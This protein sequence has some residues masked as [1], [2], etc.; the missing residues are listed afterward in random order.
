MKKLALISLIASCSLFANG[1]KIPEN[2]TNAV[3][4]SAANVAHSDGADAAYYNP[5]NM[6]FMEDGNEIDVNLMYI[7]L[8]AT[9]FKGSGTMDGVDINANDEKFI[10]PS[11][12]Y[13]SPKFGNARFGLSIV[14]PGGLTK[15]W[16]DSPAVD[17]AEEFTLKIIE[18][19]PTI[20]YAIN[21]EIAV[22]FGI[23]A[24]HSS[25]V[26]KST[27]AVSRDLTGESIDMGYNVAVSYKPNK[28]FDLA[29]TYR[30]K[31]DL[32]VEGDASLYDPVSLVY[33][34][35]A[36]VTVPLPACLNVAIAHNIGNTTVELVYERNFWSAYKKLD[37]DYAGNIGT[38]EPYFDAP[39]TKDWKDSNAFRLGVTHKMDELT[40]MA[41]AVYSESP[42][43]DERLSFELPDANSVS[44]SLGARYQY[45]K[46]I[47]VGLSAL[48]SM[49]EKRDVTN[50]DLSGEFS[51]SNI[52]L[53]SAGVGYK[54]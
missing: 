39:I 53:V 13:V 21:N 25:G 28:K 52:L 4:L 33:D 20:S 9:N 47:N 38:L 37:F 19:N 35:G 54:F 43:K 46:Q 18:V 24:I 44:V 14:S 2:S 6:A 40:L 8:N 23:R 32:T 30:S 51:N 27:S 26:V 10:V 50:T 11:V 29:L 3:A 45:N 16:S 5:A 15:R 31:V 48:Y 36:N 12:H 49:V 1:Y 7:G 41:G 22:A 17:K 42:V 34:G